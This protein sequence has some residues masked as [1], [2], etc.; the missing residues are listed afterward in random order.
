MAERADVSDFAA[1]EQFRARLIRYREAALAAIASADAEV[2][3]T[4]AWLESEQIPYWKR[5]VRLAN[6]AVT[7]AKTKWR[8]KA[9]FKDATGGRQSAI[10]EKVALDRAL[11]RLEDAQGRQREARRQLIK[12]RRDESTYKGPVGRLTNFVGGRLADASIELRQ[13]V[14][15][16]ERYEQARVATPTVVAANDSGAAAPSGPVTAEATEAAA[17]TP[18]DAERLSAE[19]IDE[20]RGRTP[21]TRV[22]AHT[23]RR[24]PP[25][26][27]PR[28]S[29][30]ARE[31]LSPHSAEGRVG[32]YDLLTSMVPTTNE[33]TAIYLERRE[34]AAPGDTGWH[35]GVVPP[36]DAAAAAAL[37]EV[38]PGCG[39]LTVGKLSAASPG[40]DG[41]LDLPVGT[42]LVGDAAGR[43]VAAFDAL[44]RELWSAGTSAEP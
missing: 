27:L 34:A 23:Q 7:E 12:L 14:E 35:V 13:V 37:A 40:W 22:R 26:P 11:L 32:K 30:E 42:L 44:G 4:I 31:A 16:L 20:I 3:R 43:L 6:D 18:I 8:E 21:T 41:L 17:A 25:P 29:A 28:L 33:T 9:L 1:I 38:T 19:R 39:T 2:A 5:A 15:Q 36:T 10:D 24:A